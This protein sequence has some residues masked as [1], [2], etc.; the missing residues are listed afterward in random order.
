MYVEWLWQQYIHVFSLYDERATCQRPTESH[1]LLP[2]K[3]LKSEAFECGLTHNQRTADRLTE[4]RI[5]LLSRGTFPRVF[6][7]S[8][9]SARSWRDSRPPNPTDAVTVTTTDLVDLRHLVTGAVARP[10]G[11]CFH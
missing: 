10:D 3:L 11:L 9:F 1:I 2:W 5:S 7:C 4:S 8:R 6:K